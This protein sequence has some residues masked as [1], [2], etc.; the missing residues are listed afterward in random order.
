MRYKYFF[1]V[2]KGKFFYK[3]KIEYFTDKDFI[4]FYVFI[5]LWLKAF[6]VSSQIRP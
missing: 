4:K 6:I 5:I 1:N 2:A 3:Y